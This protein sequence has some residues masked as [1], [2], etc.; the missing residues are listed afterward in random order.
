MA[1]S[2]GKFWF[3]MLRNA[4]QWPRFCMWKDNTCKRP[5]LRCTSLIWRPYFNI[6]VML[7]SIV[8]VPSFCGLL[9]SCSFWQLKPKKVHCKSNQQ[10]ILYTVIY[11]KRRP[12]I[13]IWYMNWSSSW[14]ALTVITFL[15]T[16]DRC[17]WLQVQFRTGQ[18]ECKMQTADWE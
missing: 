8:I 12:F 6:A 2:L 11:S 5:G 7:Q 1:C 13:C 17:Y 3:K 14:S 18:T 9:I 4:L 16:H 10:S 15:D